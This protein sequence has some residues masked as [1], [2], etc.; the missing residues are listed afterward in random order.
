MEGLWFTERQTKGLALSCEVKETL[1][2]EETPFQKIVV[3]NTAEFGRM[4]TL[5]G[6][7]QTTVRDEFFY[8]EMIA[9]VPLFTHPAPRNVLVV[10]GGD[11]GTIREVIKHPSVEKAVLAE[12]DERVIEVSRRYLPEISCALD[13]ARVQ[14]RV[15]DGIKHVKEHKEAYDVIIVDST[16]PIGPAVELFSK[17]F[18]RAVSAALKEDGIFVAQTESPFFNRK[19]LGRIYGYIKDIFPVARLYLTTVPTYPGGLWSF[20]MGSKK[21]DPLQ[22]DLSNISV[23]DTRYYTPEIHKAAFNLPPFVREVIGES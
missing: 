20:T 8:H 12:I 16:D 7:I 9:L 5:D 14:I 21:Y 10:G 4:L 13:D 23:P 6:I 3:V 19:L 18:Y 17:Q 22:V 1:H 11:G 2:A 15:E